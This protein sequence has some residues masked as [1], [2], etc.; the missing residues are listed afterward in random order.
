MFMN[1]I[2]QSAFALSGDKDKSLI[3]G[4]NELYN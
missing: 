4:C 2:A 1:I 3:A